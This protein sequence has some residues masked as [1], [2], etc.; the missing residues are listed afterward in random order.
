MSVNNKKKIKLKK[1]ETPRFRELM[2]TD[3]TFRKSFYIVAVCGV[4]FTILMI[5]NYS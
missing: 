2:E 1:K 5:Y 3:K 4:L